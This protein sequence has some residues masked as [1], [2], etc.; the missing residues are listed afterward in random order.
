MTIEKIT[1]AFF[2]TPDISSNTLSILYEAGYVPSVIITSPDA[3]SGRGMHSTPSPVKEWATK[4]NIPCLTLSK[5]TDDFIE[6]FKTYNI[7]LSIVVAYGHIL[8]SALIHLP[9]HGTINIHYSLLPQYRGAS[10]IEQ[11][12]LNGDTVT[13]ITIQQME[14]KLDSGA[15]L[16]QKE[17]PISDTDTKIKLREKLTSI[18]GK[19]LVEL[20]PHI[21]HKTIHPTVQNE[22]QATYCTK[23]KK[24]D[25]L[26]DIKG[27]ARMNFNKYRAFLRWP[28]VY[29]FVNSKRIKITQATY[30]NDSFIIE[31]VIPEGK[32]ETSY[33]N[34]LAS[35]IS[36]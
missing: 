21:I 24:E 23:I 36:K 32:K 20:L 34:F 15:C 18:G 19:L 33:E 17:I 16:S 26:I 31:R 14:F 13:G 5:V 29:F 22:S 9:S 25:G 4:H 11:A 3:R 7:D 2:G 1:Y 28:D 35:N 12:L 8:P 27:D 30:E 6:E 10:P